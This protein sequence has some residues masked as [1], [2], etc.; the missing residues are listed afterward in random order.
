MSPHV[1][2]KR[3]ALAESLAK[4]TDRDDPAWWRDGMRDG[5]LDVAAWMRSNGSGA[6]IAAWL[7]TPAAYEARRVGAEL[8]RVQVAP[9][10]PM[11]PAEAV[12]ELAQ[13]GLWPWSHDDAAP[14]WWCEKC[15]GVGGWYQD[16][17]SPCDRCLRG[18]AATPTTHDA[19]VAVTSLGA[20][21]VARYV[22]LANE[23]AYTAGRKGARVV[24]RVMERKAIEQWANGSGGRPVGEP[25]ETLDQVACIASSSTKGEQSTRDWQLWSKGWQSATPRWLSW[26]RADVA[27]AW[28]AI[29]SLTLGE[30]ET[31]QPTGVHL[32]ELHASRIV[33]GVESIYS[34]E[35]P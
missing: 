14:Q 19:I 4:L 26:A 11:T 16:D 10:H 2:P 9:P 31:P 3:P 15:E 34:K 21:N 28:P 23:I 7:T 30:G 6:A 13:A 5:W 32:V 25:P 17:F 20:S 24:F 12:Q 22:S 35:G 1:A 8:R 27:A 29:R 33:L 18:V